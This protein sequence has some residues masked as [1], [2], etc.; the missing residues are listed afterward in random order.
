MKRLIFIFCSLFILTQFSYSQSLVKETVYLKNGSVIKGIVIEHI[1]EQS[2]KIQTADGSI[3]VYKTDEVEKITKD[4]IT[5][6]NRAGNKIKEARTSGNSFSTAAYDTRGYRGFID[7]GYTIGTGD[8]NVGRIELTTS[9]GY[10]INPYFFVGA[11]TGVNY[12]CTRGAD[13]FIIPVFADIR[14]NFIEGPVVPFATL[15]L[16]YSFSTR[17]SYDGGLYLAPAVGV[18]FM[19][20]SRQALSLSLGYTCQWLSSDEYYYGYG[21]G[22]YNDYYDYYSSTT[23]NFSGVTLKLGFEF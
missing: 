3:F 22:D 14:A 8:Y 17:E 2:V 16:G 15:K 10:Q 23:E 19:L 11:G 12:Y 5:P 9:H 20:N 4:I 13:D 21:Y 7:F 18:K 6:G 1:P